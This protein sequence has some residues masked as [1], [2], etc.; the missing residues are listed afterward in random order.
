YRRRF[1]PLLVLT[2]LLLGA[3]RHITQPFEPCPQPGDLRTYH[4]ASPYGRPDILEGVIVGYP[5]RRSGFTQYRVRI[6][7]I[8]RGHDRVPVTGMAL[9]R[10]NPVFDFEYGD[11]LRIRG[12]PT[13]P[14]T[15]ADFNYRRYLARRGVH[16]VIRAVDLTRLT[17]AQGHP[18]L[19]LLYRVRARGSAVLNAVLPEPYAALA[20]GMILG[21]ESGIPREL[22]NQFNL[23]GT[24]HVIVIS[25]SNIALVSGILLATTRRLRRPRLAAILTLVGIVFYTLLVG[26]DAAVTRAAL[27]G[28]LAVMAVALGR[29]S[30]ALLSLFLAGLVML[31]IHP[32]TL[33]DVGFQLSFT[34]T[35]GLVLFSRPLRERW[36]A[37]VGNH[38]PRLANNIM[39]EGLLVTMAA[40]ITTLPLIVSYFGRLSLIAFLANLL[41][42]PVQPLILTGGGLAM[43]TGFL[44]LPL[45]QVLAWIPRAGLWWTV[46]V[47]E[48]TAR[49]PFGSV[50]VGA[51]G[52]SLAVLVFVGLGLGFIGWLFRQE[53][54]A[55]T[56]IPPAWQP[57]L[58]RG[59]MLATAVVVPLW[60]L[61]AYREGQPDGRLHLLVLGRSETAD[62]LIVGP[63][64]RR[65]LI[66]S[67]RTSADPPLADA[68][69]SQPTG[70][71]PFDIVL[72]AR[73]AETE[74][75][76]L[77]ADLCPAAAL[78]GLDHPAL[79]LG[80][81]ITLEEGV[82]L[83]WLYR[84]AGAD[85]APLFLLR[86]GDF[87]ALLPF[88]LSQVSQEA[89]LDRLP[90]GI[91]VVPAPFP[92]SGFW[93]HPDLIARLRPQAVLVPEGVTYP[94]TVQRSLA[95]HAGL[96]TIPAVGVTTISSD[97]L[98]FTLVAH[99]YPEEGI[100]R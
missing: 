47:V 17:S 76:P 94:P 25:G 98:T 65:M 22:Y 75:C 10:T 77:S 78:I 63:T 99:P 41:I 40:Q 36:E 50:V 52:R 28:G 18:L 32:L 13:A 46:L 100:R 31:A 1:I 7:A 90:T 8:W 33:W 27:M 61:T 97:G 16:T 80:S 37:H 55:T 72:L 48:Q 67:G 91:T 35:L 88:A 83:T 38:L 6:D 96:A 92:G 93:P 49:V 69:R 53:Q 19:A 79:G 12:V 59:L 54:G 14:P 74:G 70:R 30:A 64:G 39:A 4:R 85:E 9:V 45:A 26:A 11:R 89:L 20:N 71:R 66:A 86:Y 81:V 58:H 29:Q 15:F 57:A 2:F 42:L 95:S 21:I 56:L 87:T 43:L 68:V 82:T 60:G 34:A 5:D 51:W 84:P 24:S 44:A 62:F 73:E 23:T 3:W